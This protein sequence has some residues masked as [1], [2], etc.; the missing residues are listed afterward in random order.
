MDHV[1]LKPRQLLRNSGYN[2][3]I[4]LHPG[5]QMINVKISTAISLLLVNLSYQ[6]NYMFKSI[7]PEHCHKAQTMELQEASNFLALQSILFQT[8]EQRKVSYTPA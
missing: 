4:S 2:R 1:E 5:V 3:P 7:V 6:K 8:S